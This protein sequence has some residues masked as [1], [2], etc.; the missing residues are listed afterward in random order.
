MNKNLQLPP[1]FRDAVDHLTVL[2]EEEISAVSAGDFERMKELMVE[3]QALVDRLEALGP[4]IEG[5]LVPDV[6]FSQD[7]RDALEN[8]RGLMKRDTRIIERA[9]ATLKE[10][11]SQILG[12][13]SDEG[14][15]GL[16]DAKG[17]KSKPKTDH[18]K[19]FDLSL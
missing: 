14:P 5:V 16:Y 1:G 9:V 8:L 3:K 7:L 15:G 6:E 2:L 18:S 12:E 19:A 11:A 4:N 17:H 13:A 10:V